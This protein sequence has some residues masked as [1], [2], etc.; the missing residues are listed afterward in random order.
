MSGP[1]IPQRDGTGNGFRTSFHA[2]ATEQPVGELDDDDGVRSCS[3]ATSRE[4]EEQVP[5]EHPQ[6]P[7][8]VATEQ[9]AATQTAALAPEP[10]TVATASKT[11]PSVAGSTISGRSIASSHQS[12]KEAYH[13][14]L[15]L[16]EVLAASAVP[17]FLLAYGYEAAS[18]A[19]WSE[20]QTSPSRP[21]MRLWILRHEEV[22]GHT[23]YLVEC[24]L[25]RPGAAVLHWKAPRRLR[26]LREHLHDHVKSELGAEYTACFQNARFAL[27]G[28]LP[29]TTERLD[30]W[31]ARLASCINRRVVTP[32]VAA[33]ALHFLGPPTPVKPVALR[34]DGTISSSSMFVREVRA[35]T[36]HSG[37]PPV[38]FGVPASK[39]FCPESMSWKYFI[40]RASATD[41]S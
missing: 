4:L 12:R 37:R 16:T 32:T 28:G 35:N 10:R 36:R 24:S 11:E 5:K 9:P 39:Y 23:W 25:S 38:I 6:L 19:V 8:G 3:T 31:C 30:R 15:A 7:E 13:E 29:G 41:V 18:A 40:N 17:P 21:E 1:G 20:S 27:R 22:D 34:A 14:S 33:I 26:Q 2:G